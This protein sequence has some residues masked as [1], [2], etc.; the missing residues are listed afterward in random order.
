MNR[1]KSLVMQLATATVVGMPLIAW[2]VAA[3]LPDFDYASYIIGNSEWYVCIPIG[4]A[5]GAA[6]G[7][8]AQFIVS[9]KFMRES[10]LKY[11]EMFAQLRLNRGEI[12]FISVCAGFGEEVLFRGAI[13]PHLGVAVTSILFVALHGYLSFN[14][15]KLSLYG[16]FMTAVIALMGWSVEHFGLL[17]AII[18]HTLIDVILLRYL[19]KESSRNTGAVHEVSDTNTL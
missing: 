5:F 19:V 12:L 6:A 4:L 14:N 13:Q 10:A 9:R 18:A 15:W 11:V 7:Y 1:T 3:V 16:L 2:I 8:T 17:P